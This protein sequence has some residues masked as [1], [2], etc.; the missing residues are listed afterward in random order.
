[1]SNCFESDRNQVPQ[2]GRSYKNENGKD[3][4]GPWGFGLDLD[5]SVWTTCTIHIHTLYIPTSVYL[6]LYIS[7]FIYIS[8]YI[9]IS[10]YRYI[11]RY[12]Y[13]LLRNIIDLCT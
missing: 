1:M 11:E 2:W 12:R 5:L 7:I 6:N 3:K 9:P 10:T 4:N 13:K 8:T